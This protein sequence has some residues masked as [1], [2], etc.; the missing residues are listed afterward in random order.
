MLVFVAPSLAIGIIV[1][2]LTG[3]SYFAITPVLS[4]FRPGSLA[5]SFAVLIALPFMLC[6]VFIGVKSWFSNWETLR[7]TSESYR[8]IQ[9][10]VTWGSC[11]AITLLPCYFNDLET[12]TAKFTLARDSTFPR[13]PALKAD[14][15]YCALTYISCFVKVVTAVDED[16]ISTTDIK[17]G[18]A[19]FA[20]ELSRPNLDWICDE[21]NRFLGD[22][23][24]CHP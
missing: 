18:F 1:L 13:Y 16:D 5:P 24:I 22:T 10:K 15:S 11:C 6:V 19:S 23:Q 20:A 8:L 9:R 4:I 14:V 17:L 3:D 2:T 21:I 7:I 12:G